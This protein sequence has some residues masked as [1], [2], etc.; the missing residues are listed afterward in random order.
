MVARRAVHWSL[1]PGVRVQRVDGLLHDR[2]AEAEQAD[3]SEGG[4]EQSRGADHGVVA[5]SRRRG[6]R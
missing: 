2:L 5:A 6:R 3:V 4:T 1:V